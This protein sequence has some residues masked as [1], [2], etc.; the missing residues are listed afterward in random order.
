MARDLENIAN[1][2][3]A[4]G[5]YPSGRVKDSSSPGAG[6]GVKNNEILHGDWSQFFAKLL[7]DGSVSP[8]DLP[9]NTSNGFQLFEAFLAN[10]R[11]TSASET[12]KGTVE[13][14]TQA[15]VDAGTDTERFIT[16]NVLQ[17]KSPSW[18]NLTLAVGASVVDGDTPQYRINNKRI[19]LRGRIKTTAA[20]QGVL[21][22]A[23]PTGNFPLTYCPTVGRHAVPAGIP[24]NNQGLVNILVGTT[25]QLYQSDG[26]EDEISLHGLGWYPLR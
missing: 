14:A 24:L 13:R 20:P 19:E 5:D 16:P 22:D 9:D 26:S 4:D 17:N 25:G 6:D 21:F 2:D 12:E 8:N 18:I 11:S 10:I 23:T 1:T 3:P 7:R 15:E